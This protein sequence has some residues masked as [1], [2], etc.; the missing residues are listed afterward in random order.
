MELVLSFE[1]LNKITSLIQ[2]MLNVIDPL[3]C[4]EWVS[5]LHTGYGRHHEHSWHNIPTNVQDTF[6]KRTLFSFITLPHITKAI[7]PVFLWCAA[8]FFL[9]VKNHMTAEQDANHVTVGSCLGQVGS[10]KIRVSGRTTHLNIQGALSLGKPSGHGG[11][12]F[13]FQAT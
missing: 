13:L 9:P 3:L 2:K 8:C 4:L 11:K 5:S 7:K 6:I 12:D 1:I 10:F